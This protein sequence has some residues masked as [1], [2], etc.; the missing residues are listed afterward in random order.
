[1]RKGGIKG[2]ALSPTNSYTQVQCNPGEVHESREM[3]ME[4]MA[5]MD[6][7][8]RRVG[9]DKTSQKLE[10]IQNYQL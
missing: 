6:M 3:S 2:G 7:A 1:M 4:V 10:T 8:T 9:W 5:I